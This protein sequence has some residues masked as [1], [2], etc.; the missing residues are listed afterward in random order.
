MK[1]IM[2][3][4]LSI[5]SLI[6]LSL[7]AITFIDIHFQIQNAQQ[8]HSDVINKIQAS[9]YN[10]NV[11]DECIY[12]AKGNQYELSVDNLAVYS[13][14]KDYRVTLDYT[15]HLYFFD[16]NTKASLSGYAR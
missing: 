1:N 6:V 3:I 7:F 12:T 14:A 15:I 9:N 13:S 8:Y 2:S 4:S 10:Q 16:T 11:I 5:I